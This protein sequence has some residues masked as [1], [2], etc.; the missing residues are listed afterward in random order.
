MGLWVVPEGGRGVPVCPEVSGDG[1]TRPE[2][3]TIAGAGPQAMTK[4]IRTTSNPTDSRP[5]RADPMTA[6]ILHHDPDTAAPQIDPDE[7]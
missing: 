1:D 3:G 5:A 6:H 2:D 4:A 7:P